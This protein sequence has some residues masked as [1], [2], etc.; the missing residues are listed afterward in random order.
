[1]TTLHFEQR[2]LKTTELLAMIARIG[3]EL[4][5][6]SG[7]ATL[8][9]VRTSWLEMV[10]LMAL[11]PAPELRTCPKCGAVC[12]AAA[13]RCMSCWSTL[14]PSAHALAVAH[15]KEEAAVVVPTPA[16]PAVPATVESPA[17]T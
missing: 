13:T 14:V 7:D 9:T 6:P 2:D 11:E 17:V 3:A 8:A 4:A 15:V 5:A 1:M 16:V 10:K 12:I